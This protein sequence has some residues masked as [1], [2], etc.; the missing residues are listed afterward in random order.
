MTLTQ[1]F[2]IT[3][4]ILAALGVAY[5]FVITI[6]VWVSV[7][8][9]IVLASALRKPILQLREARIPQGWAVAI[10]YGALTVI[11]FTTLI[12]V[13]PPVINQFTGYMT[14]EDRLANRVIGAKIW[15]ERTATDIIGTPFEMGI[16]NDT[17]RSSI[18][19]VVN[20]LRVTA[21]RLLGNATGFLGDFVL[22]IAMSLYWMS[23]RES[24]EN[25]LVELA[26]IGRRGQIHAILQE[27][28]EVLG[29]YVRSI[30]LVSLIVG[31]A[32]FVILTLF[33]VTSAASISFFY[34]VATAIPIVG[35]LIGVVLATFIGLLTSPT[36]AVIALLVT[37]MLQQ[38]ENYWLTPRMMSQGADFDPMLVVVFVSMGFSLGGVTGALLSIPVAGAVSIL[39][40]HM[41]IEPRKASVTPTKVEGGVL[42]LSHEQ[43]A[44]ND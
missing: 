1:I 34:A 21:P 32:C 14:N 7:I 38:V 4:T 2:K 15:M 36:N 16:E 11:T 44:S 9:A 41:I 37:F 39:I 43:D 10:V 35:G 3:L 18:N 24:A 12:L 29:S 8:V 22:V 42:L 25:F 31:V 17:I 23:T 5:I 28:E 19:D 13:L 40:K 33:R 30:V 6:N 27:I 20:T 26:P